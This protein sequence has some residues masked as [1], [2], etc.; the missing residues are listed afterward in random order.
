MTPAFRNSG[1][2]VQSGLRAAACPSPASPCGLSV[3]LQVPIGDA[4]SCCQS[5]GNFFPA[6]KRAR[7]R[8]RHYPVPAEVDVVVRGTETGECAGVI[9]GS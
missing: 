2:F 6:A 7:E 9:D 4:G 3:T 8:P 1:L 5:N